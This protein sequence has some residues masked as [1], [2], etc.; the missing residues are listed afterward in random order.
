METL[1]ER[2]REA[3][4]KKGYIQK[5]A[6]E[7]LGISERTVQNHES[8]RNRPP[9]L[10][11][12]Q[13]GSLY[14]LSWEWLLTGKETYST[15]EKPVMLVHAPAQEYKHSDLKTDESNR[16]AIRTMLDVV[17]SSD[18]VELKETFTFIIEQIVFVI[19][20]IKGG[21]S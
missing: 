17:L 6:A 3:R 8:N 21:K 19:R 13:Y 5:E 20:K 12:K 4:E 15:M 14:D 7:L 18:D 1:G 16:E 9:R 2:L 10:R 11:L